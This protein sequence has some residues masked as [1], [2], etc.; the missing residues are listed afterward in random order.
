MRNRKYLKV[1]NRPESTHHGIQP[2]TVTY[3]PENNH[4]TPEVTPI[5]TSTPPDG[6]TTAPDVVKIPA[7]PQ[8]AAR[9]TISNHEEQVGR[10]QRARK[11]PERLNYETLGNPS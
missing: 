9:E 8:Q 1:W 4:L 7:A 10:P 6:G 2:P 11:P 3:V 5:A